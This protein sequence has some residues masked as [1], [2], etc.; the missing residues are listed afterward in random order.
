MI[1]KEKKTFKKM[2]KV[3]KKLEEKNKK[4]QLEIQKKQK[5]LIKSLEKLSQKKQENIKK[6]DYLQNAFQ[7][8]VPEIKKNLKKF[9]RFNIQKKQSIK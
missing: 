3:I 2:L 4:L 8:D 5:K 1:V 9:E 7:R 6:F